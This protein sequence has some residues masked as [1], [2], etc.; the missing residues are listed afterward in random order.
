MVGGCKPMTR[1][2]G[3]LTATPSAITTSGLG[4]HDEHCM[5]EYFDLAEFEFGLFLEVGI[6]DSLMKGCKG[7]LALGC[8]AVG[9]AVEKLVRKAPL[10]IVIEYG[11]FLEVG[12]N[13]SFRMRAGTAINRL[14][15]ALD[16]Q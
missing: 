4:P 12:A 6:D 15:G 2:L 5:F 10:I 7:S 3:K 1:C 9:E 13:P 11:V 8:Q 16:S 14:Y